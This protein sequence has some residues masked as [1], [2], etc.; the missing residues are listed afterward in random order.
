MAVKGKKTEYSASVWVCLVLCLVLLA[1]TVSILI[2]SYLSGSA[3]IEDAALRAAL[4]EY[5]DKP[6]RHVSAQDLAQIRAVRMTENS[7]SFGSQDVILALRKNYAL[8]V[9][10]T[11]SILDV[12]PL[13]ETF[14]LRISPDSKDFRLFSELSYLSLRGVSSVVSLAQVSHFSS[15]ICLEV[16][17]QTLVDTD[18]SALSG[19]AELEVLTVSG[20]Q[21]ADVAALGALPHLSRVD[22]SDN[23]VSDLSAL[24]SLTELKVLSLEQNRI[25]DLGPLATLGSLE[26]L[27]V[28]DNALA[29]LEPVAS[30]SELRQLSCSNATPQTES[31]V[32][33]RIC[34][35]SPIAALDE[36]TH[37]YASYNPIDSAEALSALEGLQVV[38]MDGCGLTDTAP[39]SG[40]EQLVFLSL[41]ENEI[42]S[43]APL[44]ELEG[45][46]YL[47]LAGNEIS[48]ASLLSALTQTQI[49]LS[50]EVPDAA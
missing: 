6:A 17:G 2:S 11:D 4:S 42:T 32:A 5:F 10:D 47:Y 28:S 38:A 7:V 50:V 24:S 18:L 8:S 49:D 37:L 3:L 22:L 14:S 48:D 34:D 31:A 45:L 30:L 12:D 20:G 35:L 29:S 27:D 23:A 9:S 16:S 25:S 36:L 41:M 43:V 46:S 19:L 40:K 39:F 26:Y 44:S 13:F 33:N 1:G 21:I 15:L